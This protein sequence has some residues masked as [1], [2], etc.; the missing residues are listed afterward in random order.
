[1]LVPKGDIDRMVSAMTKMLDD[2]ALRCELG[3]KALLRVRSDFSD[4]AVTA[5]WMAFYRQELGA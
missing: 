2:Q 4:T 1:M 3:R 5:A